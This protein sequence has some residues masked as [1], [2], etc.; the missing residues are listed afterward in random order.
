MEG[1]SGGCLAG[2]QHATA[3]V[4]TR[5]R[6]EVSLTTLDATYILPIARA[7]RRHRRRRTTSNR[8]PRG[9]VIVVDASPRRRVH[10]TRGELGTVRETSRSISISAPMG[11]VGNVP[12]GVLCA[13]HR[14]WSP[15]TTMSATSH[16]RWHRL[17]AM[18]DHDDVV[19]PQ[20]YF[21]PLLACSLGHRAHPPQPRERRRH[22]R[23]HRRAPSILR[24]TGRPAT[25]SVMF[26]NTELVRTVLAA[27]GHRGCASS[28]FRWRSPPSGAHFWSQRVRQAMTS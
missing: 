28:T 1:A 12:T 27:G 16:P 24:A 8:S 17:V 25:W 4:E 22:G 15:P 18:L 5:H 21:D 3:P 19:R 11:K 23:G 2:A 13:S 7:S 10:R 26:E 9:A 20:N 6:R 14:A